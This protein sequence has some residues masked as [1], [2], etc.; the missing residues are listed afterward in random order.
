MKSFSK[1]STQHRRLDIG[2]GM[3]LILSYIYPLIV[4]EFNFVLLYPFKMTTLFIGVYWYLLRKEGY[5]I[6]L[7]RKFIMLFKQI[8]FYLVIG[9]VYAYIIYRTGAIWLIGI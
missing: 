6:N 3:L 2:M 9:I 4:Y 8:A 5:G 1:E 7:K